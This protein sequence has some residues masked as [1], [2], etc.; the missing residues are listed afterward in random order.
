MNMKKIL[1]YGALLCATLASLNSCADFLD[2]APISNMNE[3]GFYET[4]EDMKLAIVAAYATLHDVY[5][6]L[7][8]ISYFGELMSDN[9]YTDNIM[10]ISGRPG[11]WAD[12][13]QFQNGNVRADNLM[14]ED[15]WNTFYKALYRINNVITNLEGINNAAQYE[16][17]MRFLRALYYFDMVQL[18]GNVVVV[19]EPLSLKDAYDTPLSDLN[20]VYQQIISDLTFAIANLPGSPRATGTPTNN[21]ATALLGKVYL[22]QGDKS[23]AINTL[24]QVYGKYT[25]VDDYADLWDMTKKNSSEAIF[26]IQYTGGANN[27]Y[28]TYWAR[29]TPYENGVVSAWGSGDNQVSTDLW[30]AYEPNDPRQEASIYNGY[31]D[32][33]GEP[34]DKKFPK[35]W[36]DENAPLDNDRLEMANNN[37]IVLRYADVLL[38]LAEATGEARY[39]NEVRTRAGLAGYGEEGY[40]TQYNTFELAV[41]H[42]RQVE[43][44]LEFHRFFDLKR[45]NRA[46]IVMGNSWKHTQ[47]DQNQLVL[48]IPLTVIDQNPN[49]IKQ[50]TGY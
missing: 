23:N 49:V 26:E 14:V 19:T 13:L 6:P 3:V 4:E 10:T 27:P 22:T 24:Q 42:E 32:N 40:P 5:H 16:A 2:R 1:L 34:I 12:R 9:A 7:G 39:L 37:F 45:T 36:M 38:L 29:F 50:N 8:P 48:P 44:A 43:F 47:L 15:F 28:S 21:A 46:V 18:W 30:N 20:T 41:E 33:N 17:E 31:I 25:L 35:K 11:G